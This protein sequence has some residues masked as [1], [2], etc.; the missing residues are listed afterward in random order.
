MTQHTEK[1]YLTKEGLEKLKR[2]YKTL[3]EIKDLKAKD[4]LPEFLHSDELNP[5]YASFQED[6]TFLNQ[7]LAD[8]EMIL[9]RYEL[10]K[11]LPKG[12]QN[13]VNLGTT[14]TVEIDGQLDEFTIVGT[15][16]SNP[17]LG[18]ISNECPVGKALLGKKVGDVVEV[19]TPIV[20]HKCKI[21]KIKYKD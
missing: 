6:L 4:K 12:K 17:A 10:I 1:F 18:K 14:V 15:L 7:R 3:L 21:I 11:P 5:E 19:K 20:K 16:E 2:E 9:R 13:I 8:L